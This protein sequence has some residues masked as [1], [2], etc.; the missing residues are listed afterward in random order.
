MYADR[1]ASGTKRSIRDRL[2]GNLARDLGRNRAHNLK[3]QR[4]G[5]DKWKHDLYDDVK[6]PQVSKPQVGSTDLRLKLQKKASLQAHQSGK[7]SGVRDLRE[8]LSGI[9]NSQPI[10]VDPPKA[11]AALVTTSESA[12]PVKRSAPPIEAILTDV[13]K[14]SASASYSK[15]PQKK[16]D[17]T[18]D[19]LLCSLGLEKYSIQFQA[20]E[21]DMSALMHMDDDDLKALGVPMGPRKKILLALE[22]RKQG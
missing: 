2:E 21:V 22:S 19:G 8:K 7:E 3:R 15:K 4:G 13:K 17:L 18:V 20:E 11:K 16:P 5:D 12:K 10:A 6:G 9:M 14:V 1:V